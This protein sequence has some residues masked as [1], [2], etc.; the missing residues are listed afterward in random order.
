MISSSLTFR[1]I[2]V[3]ANEFQLIGHGQ[4]ILQFDLQKGSALDRSKAV[5]YI[6]ALVD[7][8]QKRSMSYT[9]QVGDKQIE[10]HEQIGDHEQIGEDDEFQDS[11]CASCFFLDVL[12]SHGD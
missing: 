4:Q 7:W 9:S 11:G 6:N 3:A 5:A 1:S 10:G 8:N 2:L 12:G